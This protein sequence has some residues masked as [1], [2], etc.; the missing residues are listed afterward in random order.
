MILLLDNFDSFT[1]N[2][3]DY[4]GQL[5]LECTVV[6]NDV[7]VEEIERLNFDAIVLSPGPGRPADAGCMMQ[8]IARWHTKVPILGICLGHQALGEFFGAKLVK[9]QK[10][11]HG[12]LSKVISSSEDKFLKD[13]PEVFDVVRYHSLV[14]TNLPEELIS[15]A[16]TAQEQELMLMRHKSLPLFGVQYHPEAHL[17]SYGL[18]LLYNW[19]QICGLSAVAIRAELA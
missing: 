15:L 1:Y 19:A 7:P 16:V 10:P 11:M 12:K 8:I 9:A 6:R 3:L 14:L 5:G 18:E 4:F 13:I 17:T 2:L